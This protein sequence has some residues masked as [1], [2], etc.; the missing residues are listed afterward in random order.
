[1]P[2]EQA[3]GVHRRLLV[4]QAV[5]VSDVKHCHKPL[6]LRVLLVAVAQALRKVTCS[7]LCLD[8]L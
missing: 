6:A 7:V 5:C 1:M 2:S 8:L 4:V 3:Q